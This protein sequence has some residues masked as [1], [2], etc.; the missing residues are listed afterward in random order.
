MPELDLS[1]LKVL[2]SLELGACIPGFRV[3]GTLHATAIEVFS[4]ITS[5]M[6][7]EIV[8]VLGHDEIA[9]LPSDAALVETLSAMHKIRPFK[10][11]FLL[12]VSDRLRG[13]GRRELVEALDS[14]TSKG[15]L[16]FL[17]SPPTICVRRWDTR[18]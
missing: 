7:S 12:M 5:L 18:H 9:R 6:F 1:G 10:L 16:D 13:V 2:R 14:V 4:T 8:V 15:S 3:A 17:D 11:V